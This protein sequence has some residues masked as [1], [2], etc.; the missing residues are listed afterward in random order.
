MTRINHIYEFNC[1]KNGRSDTEFVK[2]EY[3][4]NYLEKRIVGIGNYMVGSSSSFLA[5]KNRKVIILV[6]GYRGVYDKIVTVYDRMAENIDNHSRYEKVDV[7]NFFWPSSWSRTLGFYFAKKR[8]QEAAKWL[9]RAV[10]ALKNIGY[11]EE[12]IIIQG[13]SLGCEVI[14][15]FIRREVAEFVGKVVF[16]APA[17]TNSFYEKT[18]SDVSAGFIKDYFKEDI[19]VVFSKNDPVLKYFFR[20]FPKEHWSSAALG[21]QPS[22][23]IVDAGIFT[24]HDYSDIVHSHSGH[25]KLKQYYSEIL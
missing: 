10:Q 1:R 6:H 16:A 19:H 3:G 13:H 5:D 20:L 14:E 8:T 11:L 17:I 18:I 23:Q 21:H 9:M 25:S 15:H 4:K 7:L 2:F 22:K 12:N 24:I